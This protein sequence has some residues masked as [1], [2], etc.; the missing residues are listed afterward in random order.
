[1]LQPL[2]VALVLGVALVSSQIID[3]GSISWVHFDNITIPSV[4]S[5]RFFMYTMPALPDWTALM[6]VHLYSDQNSQQTVITARPGGLPPSLNNGRG[7]IVSVW[8]YVPL[9]GTLQVPASGS[10]GESTWNFL[11]AATPLSDPTSSLLPLDF[12]FYIIKMMTIAENETSAPITLYSNQQFV[13]KITGNGPFSQNDVVQLFV[14]SCQM[15]SF[16]GVD[17]IPSVGDIQAQRYYSLN[18]N[19]SSLYYAINL[20]QDCN[21]LTVRIVRVPR[22]VSVSSGDSVELIDWTWSSTML[23]QMTLPSTSLTISVSGLAGLDSVGVSASQDNFGHNEVFQ[24]YQDTSYDGVLHT[25]YTWYTADLTPRYW[26]I[27]VQGGSLSTNVTLHF[28]DFIPNYTV[29][30]TPIIVPRQQDTS[31]PVSLYYPIPP[32]VSCTCLATNWVNIQVGTFFPIAPPAMPPAMGPQNPP[33]FPLWGTGNPYLGSACYVLNEANRDNSIY[34]QLSAVFSKSIDPYQ[35][36]TFYNVTKQI[37]TSGQWNPI[38]ITF[39]EYF[40]MRLPPALSSS[41][42]T[43]CSYIHHLTPVMGGIYWVR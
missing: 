23:L 5:T 19:G 27:R 35:N 34:V 10:Q 11:V 7:N 33:F 29:M 21:A 26:Y 13:Y 2:L 24:T 31:Q 3:N 16:I 43:S 39:P 9:T 41:S 42:S 40:F 6:G 28:S 15:S 4:N 32:S 1:M 14:T 38:N 20:Q 30:D 8:N 18:A 25:R 22:A 12:G 37:I 17:E 36:I